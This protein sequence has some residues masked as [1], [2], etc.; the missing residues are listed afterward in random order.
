MLVS[1]GLVRMC[2]KVV[3]E[4]DHHPQILRRPLDNVNLRG[5][6]RGGTFEGDV[7]QVAVL[8]H[9]AERLQ[10]DSVDRLRVLPLDEDEDED[11]DDRL[12]V[13][14]RDRG[15]SHVIDAQ[16]IFRRAHPG[17]PPPPARRYPPTPDR[18]VRV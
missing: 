7:S 13:D 4:R 8:E 12:G 3:T 1:A 17:R 10:R 18:G 15:R 5:H 2:T 11:V 6:P 9:V 14:A 16:R